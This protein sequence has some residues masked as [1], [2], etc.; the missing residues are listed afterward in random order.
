MNKINTQGF[1]LIK[2]GSSATAFELRDFSLAFPASDEV[3][4]EVESFGLNYAD[5]M[6]RNKLYKAAPSL[7]CVLGY[8]VVGKV[9]QTG[10]ENKTDLLGKKVVAFTRF[11]GY[12]K[13][14]L[15][16]IDSCVEIQEMPNHIALSLATQYVTAYYMCAY[17]S[18]VRENERVLIHAAAG[19]VGSALIQLCKLKNA[20]VYGKVSSEEKEVY[21]KNLGADFVINYTKTH[22][23]E[24][25]KRLL[26]KEK[27]DVSF[28]PVAGS[29]F[30]KDMKILASGGRMI[31]FG[32]SERSGKKWGI[33]SSLNFVRKMGIVIP[34]GLMMQSKNILGVNMLEIGDNKP[35][36][37]KHCL[38]AVVD[39]AKNNK[40]KIEKGSEFSSSQLA[41]AHDFLESGKSMGKIIVNW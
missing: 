28:N 33:F 10:N 7:P 24:E 32:G 26:G 12:A 11:G 38:Q 35:Q 34:I 8:E 18:P 14:A 36:V 37:L 22:Y 3:V 19:G 31:L 2:Y 5:V 40:L 27:L 23:S 17:L 21:V 29:T 13:H 1:F 39:L 41:E 15:A 4:I 30:K 16:K 9:I 25:L 6:A 20:I